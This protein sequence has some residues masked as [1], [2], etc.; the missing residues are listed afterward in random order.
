MITLNKLFR[1]LELTNAFKMMRNIFFI[2]LVFAFF[3]CTQPTPPK[4]P[5]NLIEVGDLEEIPE[6]SEEEQEED[7]DWIADYDL[8]KKQLQDLGLEDSKQKIAVIEQKTKI[9]ESKSAL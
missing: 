9:I 6:L 8:R 4:P 1:Y 5:E 3:G 2:L 7:R